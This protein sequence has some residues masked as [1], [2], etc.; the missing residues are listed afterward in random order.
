MGKLPNGS[1]CCE[2]YF[3]PPKYE[4]PKG[5]SK[6]VAGESWEALHGGHGRYRVVLALHPYDHFENLL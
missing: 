6:M 5:N 3:E 4:D 1:R 2:D